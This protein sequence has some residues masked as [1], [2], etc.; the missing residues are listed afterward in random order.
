MDNTLWRTAPGIITITN[1]QQNSAPTITL[2]PGD[3]DHN[4]QID[5]LD[6]NKFISCN[7]TK[8]CDMKI[9]ADFN[10]DGEVEELDLNILLSGFARRNGD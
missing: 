5:I 2:V 1:S 8:T 6:Y 9:K 4:N 3:F 10:D 7:G